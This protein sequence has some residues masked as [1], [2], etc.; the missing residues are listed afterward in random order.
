MNYSVILAD[1]PWKFKTYSH[2]GLGRSS[3]AWYETM[4]ISDICDFSVKQF[5]LDNCVLFLWTTDPFL[6]QAFRVLDAWGFT[7]KT[8]GFY[9]VKRNV[10]RERCVIRN[11]DREEIKFRNKFVYP[12]GTGYWTRANPELCLLATRGHPYRVDASVPKLIMAPRREHS[13]K[14]DI[15]YTEIER[16]CEG[17]YLEL[18]ARQHRP[19]WDCLGNETDVFP[20]GNLQRRWASNSYPDSDK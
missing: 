6:Q 4:S 20:T 13:R 1:P 2:K 7:Y 10:R 17:P 9:W 11:G 8:V 15:V 16:L 3:E 18:F 14:P 5:A 19:H 12:I